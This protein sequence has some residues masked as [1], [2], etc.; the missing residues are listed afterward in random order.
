MGYGKGDDHASQ[1]VQFL[2]LC[3]MFIFSSTN[4]SVCLIYIEQLQM[5]FNFCLQFLCT[6]FYQAF[7]FNSDISK[8][9]TSAVTS[10]IQST[11]NFHQFQLY[12]TLFFELF[13][14]YFF[15]QTLN[16]FCNVC[17]NSLTES[18]FVASSWR[19]VLLPPICSSFLFSCYLSIFR[20]CLQSNIVRWPME[21]V[22]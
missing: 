9:N 11:S 20:Q 13:F 8:W 4:L 16:I 22:G 21:S 14:I 3:F 15:P 12:Q 10:M 19:L 7:A 6:A 2:P 5:V 1:Y 18:I 17:F